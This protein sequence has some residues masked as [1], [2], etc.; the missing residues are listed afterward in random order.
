M[1]DDDDDDDDDGVISLLWCCFVC[2]L[3]VYTEVC[4]GKFN[5][6]FFVCFL[7]GVV[8]CGCWLLSVDDCDNKRK[9]ACHHRYHHINNH[10]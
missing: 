6:V 10:L 9:N 5:E 8:F 7:S 3:L 2:L 1:I 4:T